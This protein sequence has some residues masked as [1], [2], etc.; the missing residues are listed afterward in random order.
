MVGYTF[1]DY[2]IRESLVTHKLLLSLQSLQKHLLN[3]PSGWGKITDSNSFGISDLKT[4]L[5]IIVTLNIDNA[6]F[7]GAKLMKMCDSV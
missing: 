5:S 4:Q 3:F 7:C 6:G 1:L 2:L